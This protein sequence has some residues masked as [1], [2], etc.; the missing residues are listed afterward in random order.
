MVAAAQRS[1]AA[2]E[3]ARSLFQFLRG[4]LLLTLHGKPLAGL[5]EPQNT[6]RRG[7]PCSV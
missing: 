4:G 1:R 6:A 3:A 5:I 2:L 7:T